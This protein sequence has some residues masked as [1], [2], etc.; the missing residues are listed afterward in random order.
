M[1]IIGKSKN[2]TSYKLQVTRSQGF[3]L[4]ELLVSI[5]IMGLLIGFSSLAY[6]NVQKNSD[7]SSQTSQLVNT[8]RQV[9]NYAM[10][11]QTGMSINQNFLQEDLVRTYQKHSNQFDE[12]LF[13]RIIFKSKNKMAPKAYAAGAGVPPPT[14]EQLDMGIHFETD[15][16]IFFYGSIYN[17]EDPRNLETILPSN[18]SININL[19]AA[20]LVFEALTGEIQGYDANYNTISISHSDGRSHSLTVN[21]LGVV[22]VD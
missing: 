4:L 11:G 10:T 21:K 12:N 18:I 19:P 2:V 15:R 13:H 1:N 6:L 5:G 20:D 22:D 9:Q 7:L 16:Y 17:P 8:V 14:S 3:T